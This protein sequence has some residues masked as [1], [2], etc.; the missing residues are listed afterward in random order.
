MFLS[1]ENLRGQRDFKIFHSC[2]QI[3]YGFFLYIYIW[4]VGVLYK[5]KS[6]YITLQK[7]ILIWIWWSLHFWSCGFFA[8]H[9]NFC[10]LDL[11]SFSPVVGRYNAHI[12][13]QVFYLNCSFTDDILPC[14]ESRYKCKFAPTYFVFFYAKGIFEGFICNIEYF[15]LHKYPQ[16]IW[17]TGKEHILM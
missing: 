11:L 6:I 16:N 5:G 17:N 8:I 4:L 9:N 14:G 12:Y 10:N 3:H 15:N 7:I 13:N 1:L 2:F